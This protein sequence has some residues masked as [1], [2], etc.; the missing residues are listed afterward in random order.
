MKGVIIWIIKLRLMSEK[1]TR[2]FQENGKYFFPSL[3]KKVN[4]LR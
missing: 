1:L 3:I 2:I 4:M